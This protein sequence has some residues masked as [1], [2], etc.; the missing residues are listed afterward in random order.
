MVKDTN[1][2]IRNE[3]HNVAQN[4]FTI[5]RI[6]MAIAHL[7]GIPMFWVWVDVDASG[8]LLSP[9]VKLSIITPVR[10]LAFYWL[11]IFFCVRWAVGSLVMMAKPDIGTAFMIGITHDVLYQLWPFTLA[12]VPTF[13]YS[14]TLD[15][16]D[17]IGE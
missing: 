11:N 2:F 9:F 4:P 7:I 13:Y 3:N 1:A 8:W 17:W 16:V 5:P 6:S 14:E 15:L 12:M 10:M